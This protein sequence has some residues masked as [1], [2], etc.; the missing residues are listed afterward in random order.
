VAPPPPPRPHAAVD[1]G[2]RD[3]VDGNGLARLARTVAERPMLAGGGS[4]G[5]GGVDSCST[6]HEDDDARSRCSTC[7]CTFSTYATSFSSIADALSVPPP[8]GGALLALPPPQGERLALPAAGAGPDVDTRSGGSGPPSP[9]LRQTTRRVGVTLAPD[10][11]SP[12]SRGGGGGGGVGGGNDDSN[13]QLPMRGALRTEAAGT[14]TVLPW[15]GGVVDAATSMSLPNGPVVSVLAVRDGTLGMDV[16]PGARGST[17][18]RGGG[19]F[20]PPASDAGDDDAAV[21]AGGEGVGDSDDGSGGGGGASAPTPTPAATP[22]RVAGAPRQPPSP[23]GARAT[24]PPPPGGRAAARSSAPAGGSATRP[25]TG[26][27]TRLAQDGGGGGGRPSRPAPAA[28]AGASP[29]PSPTMGGPPTAAPPTVG[30]LL[31]A[32]RTAAALTVASPSAM[33][34]RR[35]LMALLAAVRRLAAA[36][37][38]AARPAVAAAAALTA[39]AVKAVAARSRRGGEWSLTAG[40][41]G[42]RLVVAP[43]ATGKRPGGGGSPSRDGGQ[44][45]TPAS[46]VGRRRRLSASK[47][48]VVTEIA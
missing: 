28:A 35:F 21:G 15:A 20:S 3:G 2:S 40:R 14:A 30:A 43:A 47:R 19:R 23:T 8:A 31:A 1:G 39:V 29:P 22:A 32:A 45:L 46:L 16:P 11:A 41:V 5:G 33:T 37:V 12:A 7:N 4:G 38:A 17:S 18:K 27:L 25:L 44:R 24:S 48:E 10:G 13:W 36:A 9:L 34:L 26:F 6:V 42:V